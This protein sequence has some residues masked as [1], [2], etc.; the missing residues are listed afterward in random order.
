MS[1]AAATD[2][3][4]ARVRERLALALDVPEIEEAI[5]LARRLRPWFGVAKVG[6]ELFVAEGPR[7]I[8]A[9][10]ELEYDVFA[11]LKLH[12]IPTTVARAARAA[13][14]LGVRY[15][16]A[17]AAGGG[18]ML[19]GFAEGFFDGAAAAGTPDP[20]P[21]AVTVLTSDPD[22]SAFGD[23]LD[24][25]VDAGCR[26]VVCSALEVER[27]KRRAPEFWTVVPGTRPRGAPL[28]DQA[29]STTPGEAA[30]V[31]ADILVIGRPVTRATDPE[32]A[33][34]AV[35]AEVLQTA[36]GPG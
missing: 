12:D 4:H 18:E 31:G 36:L 34:A 24:L 26:G 11:D 20:V 6:L 17:H 23:R 28:D 2:A 13:G 29:R 15:L 25:A 1:G 5:A 32:A 33:A 27:V 8:A 19:T 21:L 9:M 35:F 16:N 30:A 3:D 22:A 7:A 10:R 14:G